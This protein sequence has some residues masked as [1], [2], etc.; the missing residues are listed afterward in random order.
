MH[1]HDESAT[2]KLVI[3]PRT[4]V[5]MDRIGLRRYLETV[6]GP[7]CMNHPD[8]SG[9]FSGYVHHYAQEDGPMGF[10]QALLPDRHAMT[11]VRFANMEEMIAA[12]KSDSYR[13]VI[14]PDEDN[15]RDPE[16]SVALLAE[17]HEVI[18]GIDRALRKIF[19][20]RRL[21][22]VSDA[23]LEAWMASVGRIAHA[24]DAEL[25]GLSVN[26]AQLLEGE[27]EHLLFD[28]IGWSMAGILND[29]AHAYSNAAT[30]HFGDI[31]TL[32]LV[33][34]PKIFIS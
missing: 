8:T 11:I 27:F 13:D 9:H 20:F 22:Q 7:L 5:G 31:E 4:K 16:G 3:L 15:F 24:C 30:E 26:T 28:E 12:R 21:S 34:E 25:S 33:T 14:G 10:A 17:E 19:V 23:T 32:A 1:L 2:L 29:F 18:P 6:H